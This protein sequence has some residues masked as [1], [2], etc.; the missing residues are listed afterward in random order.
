MRRYSPCCRFL[1]DLVSEVVSGLRPLPEAETVG[2]F[3]VV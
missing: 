1:E 2:E 3:K